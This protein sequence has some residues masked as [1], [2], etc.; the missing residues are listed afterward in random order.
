MESLSL[1]RLGGL[2]R[3][4]PATLQ[5]RILCARTRSEGLT[6]AQIRS[7]FVRAAPHLGIAPQVQLLLLHLIDHTS[8]IDWEA[9]SRPIVWPS[10]DLLGAYLGIGRSQT[11]A[12]L[13]KAEACGL[14]IPKPSPNGKRYGQ[15]DADGVISEAFGIDLT[16]LIAQY[17]KFVSLAEAAVRDAK[18][19]RALQRRATCAQREIRALAALA[20]DRRLPGDWLSAIADADSAR[21]RLRR[22]TDLAALQVAVDAL[23]ESEKRSSAAILA[24]LQPPENQPQDGAIPAPLTDLREKPEKDSSTAPGLPSR[25]VPPPDGTPPP[26]DLSRIDIPPG[27]PPTQIVRLLP[28]LGPEPAGGSS[29]WTHIAAAGLRLAGETGIRAATWQSAVTAMGSVGAAIALALTLRRSEISDPDRY[30]RA[31]TRRAATH[32]LHID[33]SLFK[34]L[35]LQRAATADLARNA[36]EKANYFR[37]SRLP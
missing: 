9:P 22:F 21:E 29:T 1:Q 13:R 5:A 33:R 31:L 35:R 27:M 3:R 6:R 4:L 2:P 32:D 7:A 16:P 37:R 20:L 12:T 19:R 23:E 18:Q 25:G 26:R 24:A 17:D 8:P 15:R 10:N 28:H 14:V 36:S 30:L 34:L 11:R